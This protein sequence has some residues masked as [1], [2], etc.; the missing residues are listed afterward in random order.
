VYT[1]VCSIHLEYILVC[2]MFVLIYYISFFV[3]KNIHCVLIQEAKLS[4]G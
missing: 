2:I 3:N 4:L 1:A